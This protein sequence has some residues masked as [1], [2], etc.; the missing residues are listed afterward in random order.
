M[1]WRLIDWTPCWPVVYGTSLHPPL[2]IL[3]LLP[4]GACPRLWQNKLSK[5]TET[6]L[7]ASGGPDDMLKAVRAQFGFTHCRET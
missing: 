3:S 2:R 1:S 7:T 6:G 5:V 4:T